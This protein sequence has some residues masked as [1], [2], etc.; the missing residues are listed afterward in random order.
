MVFDTFEIP[1]QVAHQHAGWGVSFT[2][3]TAKDR[4]IDDQE[5]KQLSQ[6]RYSLRTPQRYQAGQ[7]GVGLDAGAS[8]CGGLEQIFCGIPSTRRDNHDHRCEPSLHLQWWRR[9]GVNSRSELLCDHLAQAA[10]IHVEIL[11][12]NHVDGFDANHSIGQE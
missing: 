9:R 4:R 10:W 8:T 2:K 6:E 11:L 1:L 5:T 7:T 12:Q 3:L